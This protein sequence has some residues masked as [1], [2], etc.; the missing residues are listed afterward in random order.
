MSEFKTVGIVGGGL[1]GMSWASLFLARGCEVIV[2]DPNPDAR[3]Q[4]QD[5]LPKAWDNL[6]ALGLTGA[7]MAPQP[8]V[9]DDYLA[10]RHVDFIQ[11]N[12]PEQLAAKLAIIAQ[13]EQVIRSEVVIASSTS[14]L[15][16]S[17]MQAGARSP[18]RILVAHPMNPP[19]LVPMVELVAGR[20]TSEATVATAERFYAKMERV[21]I[22]VKREVPGHLANRLTSALF[23]EAV[24]LVAE[25]IADVED[26]DKAI[27][28]G[29]GLRWALMGP[30]LTYH[31]GGGQGGYRGYL[32]NLGPSQEERWKSLG[33]PKLSEAVKAKLIAGVEDEL[34]DLD[35]ATLI[36]R[37][38]AA[39]V[40]ILKLKA[41]HRL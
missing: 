7:D 14:S 32:E 41:A 25:G 24:H 36:E 5:F 35:E 27:A 38:D 39:L 34:V 40:E 9:T 29:P 17:D 4:L 22:R 20:E 2:V 6:T 10:L 13:L 23:R 15:C 30:H 31:L 11:E 21:C 37:R 26:V 19:H 18:E 3:N 1:I 8:T 16:A 28:Y 33:N 12:G